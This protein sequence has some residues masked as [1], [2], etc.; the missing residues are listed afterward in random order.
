MTP[1]AI[2]S[3]RA[4][5]ACGAGFAAYAAQ[6]AC[7]DTVVIALGTT[8]ARPACWPQARRDGMAWPRATTWRHGST[9]RIPTT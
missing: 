2:A 9:C 4:W 3:A 6:V 5:R 8:L 1:G 7:A